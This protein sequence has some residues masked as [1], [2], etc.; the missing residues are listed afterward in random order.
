M[1]LGMLDLRIAATA[2]SAGGVLVTRNTQDFSLIADL[3][4]ADWSAI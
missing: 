1:A 2:L 3:P 4:L